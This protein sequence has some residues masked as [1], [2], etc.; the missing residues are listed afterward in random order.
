MLK[1][2]T[3]APIKSF[4]R[5]AIY[6]PSG[7][8]SMQQE[9]RGLMLDFYRNDIHRLEGILGRDLSAWLA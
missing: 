1:R 2:L 6:R 9:D 8:V 3:P 5:N 4:V 7:S